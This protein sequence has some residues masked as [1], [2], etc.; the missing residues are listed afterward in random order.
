[1][2]IAMFS[3]S[4]FGI[5][6]YR[7]SWRR[8]CTR[9]HTKLWSHIFTQCI[10]LIHYSLWTMDNRRD[11]QWWPRNTEIARA[12]EPKSKRERQRDSTG[13][14]KKALRIKFTFHIHA[15]LSRRLR[16][17]NN[18][19]PIL[20]FNIIYKNVFIALCVCVWVLFDVQCNVIYRTKHK[21]KKNR[22]QLLLCECFFFAVVV[23]AAPFRRSAAFWLLFVNVSDSVCCP[24][25]HCRWWL[26][27]YGVLCCCQRA[28]ATIT[29]PSS[30][31]YYYRIYQTSAHVSASF[32]L[33]WV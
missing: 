13:R 6:R 10:L 26:L 14:Q 8:A 5:H 11:R 12:R 9:H 28:L 19:P 3:A 23:A 24:C 1:M 7:I 18:R 4:L 16:L 21:Q 17:N 22:L 32:D 31:Y 2:M 30:L 15:H 25:A 27:L 20:Q 29:I 33:C